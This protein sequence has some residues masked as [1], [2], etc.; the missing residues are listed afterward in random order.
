MPPFYLIIFL[1]ILFSGVPVVFSLIFS[2]AAGF[3]INGQYHFNAILPQRVFAGIN[4]FPCLAV[5]L[6]MLA[7]EIMNQGAITKSLVRLS[8]ALMGH[9]RGGLAHVNILSSILFAGLSGSA[10][11]DTSAIGSLLIPAMEKDGYTTRFAAAVTAA[12]S[13]IG[14]IIPPS[15][16]M[17]IYSHVMETSVA[18]MF[19]GGFL[20]GVVMGGCLMVTTVLLSKKYDFPKR[21]KMAPPKEIATAFTGA[22]L[23]L[24]TPI[25]ILG[26]IL[27]GV[28]TPTEAAGVA[29]FY[30]LMLAM[31]VSRTLK[32]KD[33]PIIFKQSALNAAAVL[34]VVG[35]SVAFG[36][37][38]T[39]SQIPHKLGVFIA[40]MNAPV[41]VIILGMI[42]VLLIIGMF[43]DAAPA[44]M[45]MGPILAPVAMELGIH[46]IHF[47]V[48]MCVVATV[49]LATPP[50]GIVLFLAA[51]MTD[52]SVETLAKELLP[53][54]ATHI[55]AILLV[56]YIP[57]LTLAIPGWLDLL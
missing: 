51:S 21:D 34:F 12:S 38:A 43:L 6:F 27:G 3:I 5:P 41:W 32:F 31:G 16:I 13:I 23:P 18:A 24:L 40:E 54:I 33:L 15:L 22:I 14:P 35:A 28:F 44:I 47:A 1:F 45:I 20:P 55:V 48:L 37:I 26:G 10:V 53:F 17:V 8:N 36:W 56:A 52:T 29:A 19:A 46:Q 42:L 50:M 57:A 4:Q 2:S 39:I 30:A 7:G 25:I 9:L 11:A 49:G